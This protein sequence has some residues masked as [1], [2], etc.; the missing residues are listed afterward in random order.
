[1]TRRDFVMVTEAM[2]N[3]LSQL[4][5][6]EQMTFWKVV[7]TL[8]THMVENDKTFNKDQFKS[9][10]LRIAGISHAYDQFTHHDVLKNGLGLR[11]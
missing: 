11:V 4:P 7:E 8:S 1:M 9:N 2:G 3:I 5:R 6:S 10:I